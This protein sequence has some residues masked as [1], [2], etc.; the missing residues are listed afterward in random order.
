MQ[1]SQLL[2]APRTPNG[3][4]KRLYL[5]HDMQ[6]GS[7]VNVYVAQTGSRPDELKGLPTIMEVES[8]YKELRDKAKQLGILKY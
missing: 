2:I 4:A 1:V 8:T 7:L 6:D 3:N 5:V